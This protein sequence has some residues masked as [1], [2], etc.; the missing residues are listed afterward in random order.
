MY[1]EKAMS[2]DLI[3]AIFYFYMSPFSDQYITII[4]CTCVTTF[5]HFPLRFT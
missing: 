5:D 4:S 3:A 1:R 2:I